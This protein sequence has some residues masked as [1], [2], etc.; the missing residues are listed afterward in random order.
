MRPDAGLC[1]LLSLMMVSGGVG[2]ADEAKDDAQLEVAQRL[3]LEAVSYH[4]PI[5]KGE[6]LAWVGLVQGRAGDAA[7]AEA[8]WAAAVEL[9]QSIQPSDPARTARALVNIAVR[10]IEGGVIDAAGLTLRRAHDWA[11]RIDDGTTRDLVLREVIVGFRRIKKGDEARAIR[12]EVLRRMEASDDP[13]VQGK[14][15]LNRS[16][17]YCWNADLR[18]ALAMAIAPEP[19]PE[20][21]AEQVRVSILTGLGWWVVASDRETAGPVLVEALPLVR[22][23]VE[24][25]QRSTALRVWIEAMVR[26]GELDQ[27]RDVARAIATEEG[28]EAMVAHLRSTKAEMLVAVATGLT[29]AGRRTEAL[30]LLDEAWDLATVDIGLKGLASNKRQQF[31]L[32]AIPRAQIRAGGLDQLRPLPIVSM[33]FYRFTYLR[34]GIHD[35]REAGDFATVARIESLLPEAADAAWADYRKNRDELVFY[36]LMAIVL[37]IEFEELKGRLRRMGQPEPQSWA[38]FDVKAHQDALAA[39]DHAGEQ[40]RMATAVAPAILGDFRAAMAEARRIADAGVMLHV[41]R[42]INDGLVVHG[43][44]ET[45]LTWIDGLGDAGQRI[46]QLNHLAQVLERERKGRENA[47]KRE[48]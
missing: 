6:Y 16:A 5:Q 19:T 13:V 22:E 35:C 47:A 43:R 46:T 44:L 25:G 39:A 34:M 1:G 28:D 33:S 41:M 45:A 4:D 23:I 9:C 20:H 12:D 40:M 48:R 15:F 10:K 29:R 3:I 24:P 21:T 30:A 31:L 42:E 18:Q 27:A 11:G 37:R 2:L 36:D 8:S 7:A 17:V 32:T 14:R 38:P 26:I